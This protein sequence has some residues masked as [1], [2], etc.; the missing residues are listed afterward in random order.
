MT[1]LKLSNLSDLAAALQAQG[2]R[3]VAPIQ[4]DAVVRLRSWRP[5]DTVRIAA[6]PVN[7]P[8][9][10]LF[11]RCE[12]IGR[13]VLDRDGFTSEDLP[14]R[15]EK[16]VL[17]GIRP[18]D[19]AA[20]AG[21]DSVFA[22]GYPDKFYGERR[23]ATTIVSLVCPSADD[24]CFCTSVGGAP[25]STVGA[26]AM[27]RLCNGG[28][29]MTFASMTEKGKA[30]DAVFGQFSSP[31]EAA[32]DPVA[33]V[34]VLFNSE[35]VTDWC[36]KS[37][38]STVWRTLGLACLGCGA[39]AFMCPACHCFDIQ[40]ESTD[41][42]VDRLR[43]WDSCGFSQFTLHASGHNPRPDQPARW[44]QRMMHKFRYFKERFGRVAC[45]G[46]GRCGRLCPT[47]MAISDVCR[48]IARAEEV[49]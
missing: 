48:E 19:V 5:G 38:E 24:D 2:Y 23:A 3:V 14:A 39:C 11:P 30:L 28:T 41:A 4:D 35:V 42:Q 29:A 13:Y 46:C 25:D 15:A 44:R 32:V 40:D 1:L 26:D 36:S 33:E 27:L 9:D 22:W 31:G 37:F 6:L 8:K 17:L 34:P 21:L 18:C 7:S 45:T 43:N 12:A 10:F 16:T 49:R 47:G 20:L